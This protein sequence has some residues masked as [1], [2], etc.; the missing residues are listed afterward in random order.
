M[1]IELNSQRE[2]YVSGD[3]AGLIEARRRYAEALGS[4][5]LEDILVRDRNIA[6]A[7][8]VLK[9]ATNTSAPKIALVLGSGH[10]LGSGSV[11]ALLIGNGFAACANTQ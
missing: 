2:S 9:I 7:R 10:V 4:R 5:E 3:M 8:E 6:M 1:W 11:P